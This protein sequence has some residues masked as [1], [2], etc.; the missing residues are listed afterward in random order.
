MAYPRAFLNLTSLPDCNVLA[1][2]FS[3]HGFKFATVVGEVLSDLAEHGRTELPIDMFRL[4][5]L[6]SAAPCE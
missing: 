4:A 3:G 2:G 5:R 1:T 6:K